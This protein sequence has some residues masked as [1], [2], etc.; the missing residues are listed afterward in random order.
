MHQHMLF[1]MRHGH[2]FSF[3]RIRALALETTG[4]RRLWLKLVSPLLC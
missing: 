2:L 3:L 1:A 4:A